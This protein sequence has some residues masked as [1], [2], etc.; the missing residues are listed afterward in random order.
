MKTRNYLG[1]N[2]FSICLTVFGV[3]LASLGAY[4]GDPISIS[5]TSV[6]N[7]HSDQSSLEVNVYYPGPHFSGLCGIEIR[8]D[9]WG[10]ARPISVFLDAI[11]TSLPTQLKGTTAA[12]IDL[13]SFDERFM[14]SFKIETK[15]G[16][17][18][19]QVIEKTLGRNREIV[20]LGSTCDEGE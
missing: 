6:T 10:R 18:L 11:K 13:K 8:S 20:L 3:I 5:N 7:I 1:I 9:S 17:S 2:K 4:A 19:N 16:E 14:V 15:S 12:V